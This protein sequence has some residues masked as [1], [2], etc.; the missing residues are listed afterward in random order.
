[1]DPAK[2][3]VEF[4]GVHEE[5]GNP[6]M[7][8]V[9]ATGASNATSGHFLPL[10]Q[11]GRGHAQ[12]H[13]ARGGATVGRA[14]ARDRHRRRPRAGAGRTASL[15]RV[16]R[17]GAG[18]AAARE[19]PPEVRVASSG[20]SARS[21]PRIDSLEKA[22]GTA[23]FGIDVDIPDMHHA[24]VKRS[25]VI[26]GTV[27]SFDARLAHGM[28]GVVGVVEV[29]SGVAIVAKQ[30]WQ[31]R[32]AA[33]AVRVE[34][35][36]PPLAAGEFATDRGGLPACARGG[37][38]VRGKR[39]R[40][41]GKPLPRVVPSR[42]STGRLTLAHAPMEPMNAVVRIGDG[43]AEVWTGTQA[44]GIARGAGCPRHGLRPGAGDGATT[45]ISGAPLAA[46]RR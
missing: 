22:T 30:Y 29:A 42:P 6:A 41:R 8:G 5:Y 12:G 35:D 23:V 13:R 36:L 38:R 26:G 14:G 20:T 43:E 7:G 10:R 16:R 45:P 32:K 15:R 4:A 31:A 37:R 44:L 28:P 18:L 11:G 33:E 25:P 46:A 40:R 19:H 17:D 24:V 34:W 3:L 39:G 27:A 21:C 2:L 1:M 9:Q